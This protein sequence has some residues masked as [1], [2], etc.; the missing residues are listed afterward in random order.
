[1]NYWWANCTY[2]NVNYL[3]NTSIQIYVRSQFLSLHLWISELFE[4]IIYDMSSMYLFSI[5]EF[6]S[7][8][9]KLRPIFT[10]NSTVSFEGW[11]QV[12]VT[13]LL[14]EWIVNKRPNN[15]LYIS[16][17]YANENGQFDTP[18]VDVNYLLNYWDSEHQPFITAYFKS[19]ESKGHTLPLKQKVNLWNLST[20]VPV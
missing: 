6:N 20:L 19:N 15:M 12:N 3:K 18:S 1:M 5:F 17:E 4:N 10:A 11:I 2:S 9:K 16:I 13:S 14:S 7:R 8:I